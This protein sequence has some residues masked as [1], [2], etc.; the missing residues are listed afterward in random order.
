MKTTKQEN[1]NTAIVDACAQLDSYNSILSAYAENFDSIPEMV[2]I[3]FISEKI[4][5]QLAIIKRFI[6]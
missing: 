4:Q 1:S 5:E 2:N 3:S 6:V